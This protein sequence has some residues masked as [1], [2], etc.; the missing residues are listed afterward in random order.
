MELDCQR[1]GTQEDTVE[2]TYR[3]HW[4]EEINLEEEG[5][6]EVSRSSGNL[7]GEGIEQDGLKKS[8]AIAKENKS[9]VN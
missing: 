5:N 2:K 8:K 3:L 6:V 9:R 1:R 7:L 4:V